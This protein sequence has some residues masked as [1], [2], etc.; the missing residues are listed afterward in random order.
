[1]FLKVCFKG[2]SI[3]YFVCY[4]SRVLLWSV[5]YQENKNAKNNQDGKTGRNNF[6]AYQ[7]LRIERPNWFIYISYLNNDNC[8]PCLT[9]HQLHYL[10]FLLAYKYVNK[11]LISNEHHWSQ[12]L[13]F[14]P[15]HH[16]P[17]NMHTNIMCIFCSCDINGFMSF[18]YNVGQSS[19]ATI[20]AI[21]RIIMQWP[22]YSQI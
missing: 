1:M 11:L 4:Q 14:Y 2:A 19:N 3:D 16:I 15:L 18:V 10:C 17:R 6:D 12:H 9:W 22:L 7:W 21:R 5:F 13:A 20:A 8:A